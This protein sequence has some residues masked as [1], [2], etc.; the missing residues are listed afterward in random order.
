M[1]RSLKRG[2]C[3]GDWAAGGLVRSWR[4]LRGGY[5]GDFQGGRVIVPMAS[6]VRFFRSGRS[7]NAWSMMEL[8]TMIL[9]GWSWWMFV[10]GSRYLR[11]RGAGSKGSA[12]AC[13]ERQASELLTVVSSTTRIEI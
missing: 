4:V 9:V 3:W 2:A 13:F 8:E 1:A 10:D 5:V 12:G 6:Y 7:A 11:F